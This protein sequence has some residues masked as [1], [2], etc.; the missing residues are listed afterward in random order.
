VWETIAR[1]LANKIIL[2]SISVYVVAILAS[3]HVWAKYNNLL[4]TS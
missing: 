4:L 2:Q 1:H 3:W